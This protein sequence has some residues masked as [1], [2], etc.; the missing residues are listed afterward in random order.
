MCPKYSHIGV[1]IGYGNIKLK[2]SAYMTENEY[3]ETSNCTQSLTKD[4]IK[5]NC[6]KISFDLSG[7]RTFF[8]LDMGIHGQYWGMRLQYKYA[9]LSNVDVNILYLDFMV[10]FH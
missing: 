10:K 1:G 8:G 4:E 5:K 6:E 2:G 9:T 3:L 7:K